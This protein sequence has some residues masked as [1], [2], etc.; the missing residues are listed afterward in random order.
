MWMIMTMCHF[1]KVDIVDKN[2]VHDLGQHLCVAFF[3]FPTPSG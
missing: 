3:Y 1:D 2:Y